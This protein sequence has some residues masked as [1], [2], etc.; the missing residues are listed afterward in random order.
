[1]LFFQGLLLLGYLY[2][3]LTTRFLGPRRQ[4]VLHI[5]LLAIS[6]LLLPIVPNDSWKPS[7]DEDPTL[8]IIGLMAASIGLPYFLLSSTGPLVQVW[9]ARE[10]PGSVP[11]RL[12]ALS[13]FGSMLG[14][15]SYPL[16]FEPL[17]AIPHM[18]IGWSVAFACFALTCSTL[19]ALS[20]R[21]K[22][23]VSQ[24]NPVGKSSAPKQGDRFRWLALAAFPTILLMSIT[25]HL[26][27]NI[28]PVPLLW[29]LPLVL[30]LATFILCFEGRNWYRRRWY[31]PLFIIFIPAMIFFVAV[32]TLMLSG[33]GWP[34]VL[35]CTGLFVCCM[36][37]HGE[38]VRIKPHPSY[39]TSFYLMI[40]VGG[41]IGGVF[42]AVLAPRIFNDDYELVI[43]LIATL[44]AVSKVIHQGLDNSPESALKRDMW[45]KGI[46]FATTLISLLVLARYILL[47]EQDI[48]QRN[49]YGT[50]KVSRHGVGDESVK[51]L[52][53]GVI[54]HGFQ[55]MHPEKRSWSTTYYGEQ[56]GAGL[57][58]LASRT[59]SGQRVGVVGLGV[60]TMASYCREGDYY[61]FYE[62]N[63]LIIDL[64]KSEFTYLADCKAIVEIKKGDARLSL[65]SEKFQSFDLLALDAF[66]GDSVP[67]HLLTQEAFGLY[68]HHL[69]KG[70][71]L[72][73]HVTNRNLN[74]IPV[75]KAAAD[76]YKK[77]AWHV[78]SKTDENKGS[79]RADWIL[80][81][82]QLAV[83]NFKKLEV[84]F[85]EEKTAS[86]IRPWTD[87]YS[88]I[89]TILK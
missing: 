27:Q 53:H 16:F 33:I 21:V 30:Y 67:V 46:V 25:S 85:N 64:A 34:I 40:A 66:S 63:P 41:A 13:N 56:S 9:F 55:Y 51:Q 2:A 82:D 24:L 22:V 23:A 39:L 6:L 86:K 14:L 57:A 81:G 54:L 4:A 8:L 18:A 65:E 83:S 77:E 10:K 80:V 58:L 44:I 70:G 78:Q 36:V 88:S 61:K 68:F 5:F 71:I 48:R 47:D 32:P 79:T 62:I 43:A 7:G 3:H 84:D 26:T 31:L 59:F 60:G 11:Y 75:V 37:C 42:V 52:T 1:M 15:I 50:V 49:F 19:A 45:S 12:F 89:Y 72:A 38:L 20:L 73:V 35:F 87:G 74:L 69:K 29:V 28:A 76:Y 17:F